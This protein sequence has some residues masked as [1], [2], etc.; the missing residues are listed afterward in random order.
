MR[1][2]L[3]KYRQAVTKAAPHGRGISAHKCTFP[4]G[5][6]TAS[7]EEASGAHQA[8]LGLETEPAQPCLVTPSVHPPRNVQRVLGQAPR[9]MGHQRLSTSQTVIPTR[10]VPGPGLDLNTYK[11]D[12]QLSRHIARVLWTHGH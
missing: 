7:W 9:G 4:E 12:G 6:P 3:L 11:K 2:P 5:L 10:C 8:E 1:S